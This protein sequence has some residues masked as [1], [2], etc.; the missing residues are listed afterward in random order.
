MSDPSEPEEIGLELEPD[1]DPGHD[2]DGGAGTWLVVFVLLLGAV[3]V[4]VFL[5]LPDG[6]GNDPV[7]VATTEAAATESP[8]PAWE[9]RTTEP[10]P[11]TEPEPDPP[12]GAEA[13]ETTEH[14]LPTVPPSEHPPCTTYLDGGRDS[15]AD[16]EAAL[17]D[18]AG[19][20][21]WTNSSVDLSS[22]LVKA[23]AWMES[24]W[25]SDIVACDGGTG[26]MQI[27]PDT[28]D[29]VNTRFETDFDRTD[30]RDNAMLG[31]AQLQWLAKY[32]AVNYFGA[33]DPGAYSLDDD[34]SRD[35]AVP[36]HQETCLLNSV[37]SAYQ[38]GFGTVE[39]ALDAGS[40]YT[41]LQ[42]IETV[43]ALLEL[44]PWE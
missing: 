34:C 11:S 23:I 12:I 1:P 7:A 42:Y 37:I 38:A 33:S 17:D 19:T 16:V 2:P 43:R 18:A 40:G 15:A 36:D 3:A 26:L 28:E 25:Q 31:S 35:G 22:D 41:N 27:Q 13:E 32:F 10:A 4:G 29:F 39:A 24:G 5:F 9:P 21:F 14:A 44:R 20:Q 8:T 6:S 30:T